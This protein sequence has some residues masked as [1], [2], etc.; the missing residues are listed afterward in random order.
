MSVTHP[1]Y[2]SKELA[3]VWLYDRQAGALSQHL[4]QVIVTQE[5]EPARVVQ[6]IIA[7]IVKQTKMFSSCVSGTP[8]AF[9]VAHMVSWLVS[10]LIT[11]AHRW[12]LHACLEVHTRLVCLS[13]H[14]FLQCRSRGNTP[15]L[16][17]TAYG[18]TT[19]VYMCICVFVFVYLCMLFTHLGKAARLSS[20]N[21]FNA[22]WQDS[23]WLDMLPRRSSTRGMFA[24]AA[25]FPEACTT[26]E[27]SGNSMAYPSRRLCALQLVPE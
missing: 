8:G 25:T 22:F 3:Q 12:G 7:I 5:V 20:R 26:H 6:Y 1:V 24:N 23:N 4:Q 17:H 19:F 15:P 9:G 27:T 11:C 21:S 13:M 16:Q 14:G 10:M 2:A 18:N